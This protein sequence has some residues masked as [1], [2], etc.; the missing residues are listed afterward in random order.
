M[1]INNI[2][3]I[4]KFS[5]EHE[6][7]QLIIGGEFRVHRSE[8]WGNINYAENLPAGVTKDYQYYFYNGAKDIIGGFV[9]ESY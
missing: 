4:P 7:G 2:G 8:H 3:W 6:N 5:Y 9:H 1:K